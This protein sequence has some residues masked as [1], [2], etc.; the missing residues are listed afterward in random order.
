M[1]QSLI[2]ARQ[3]HCATI[4]LNR[5][6]RHN[7][8]DPVALE[9]FHQRLDEVEADGNLRILVITG[10]GRKTFCS[11]FSIDDLKPETAG[12]NPLGRLVD[13]LDALA[14]PTICALNGSLYGGAGDLA[15]ACDFRIGVEGMRMFV[16]PARLGIHYPVSGLQRYVRRLGLAA[17]KRLLLADET[18]DDR[19]LLRLGFLDHLVPASGLDEH[20]AAMT[21]RIAALAPLSVRGMKATLNEISCGALDPQVAQARVETCYRSKD[22]REALAARRDKRPPVFRG[23]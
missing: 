23:A 12:D 7:A 8:L 15:L 10:T 5:P 3:E 21:V 13:R 18:F 2:L 4:T 17:A 22:F 1:T 11:G 20:I 9:E 6:E 14:L 19:E 16:P